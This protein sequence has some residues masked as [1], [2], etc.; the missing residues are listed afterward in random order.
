M[1][2]YA[3]APRPDLILLDLNM[4]RM[5][6]LELL[7]LIKQHADWKRIPV[8]IMTGSDKEKDIVSAYDQHAN[9]YVTKPIDVE[10]SWKPCA[11]SRISAEHRASTR[12]VSGN[13]IDNHKEAAMSRSINEPPGATRQRLPKSRRTPRRRVMSHAR[14]WKQCSAALV[15]TGAFLLTI[16]LRALS[17]P[18]A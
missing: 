4:P 8:V 14:G 2:E 13:G 9:C 10:S 3:S 1:G 7:A 18:N 15:E 5:N 12:R 16:L 11:R 17:A 6:G